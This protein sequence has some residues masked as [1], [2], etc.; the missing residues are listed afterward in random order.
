MKSI[1]PVVAVFALLV[2]AS[3]VAPAAAQNYPVVCA[4]RD[5]ELVTQL[6]QIGEAQT[7]RGEILYEAFRVLT[8][9]RKACKQG[10]V[11]LA[12][13]LY[14]SIFKTSLAGQLGTSN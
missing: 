4:Q 14:D 9:A 3:S 13:A 7:V 1:K 2:C 10:R 12:L 6:E 5:V 11:E 8:R